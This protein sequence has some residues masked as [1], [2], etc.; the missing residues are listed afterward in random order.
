MPSRSTMESIHLVRRLVEQFW[1][2]KKNLHMMFIDLEK[3]Y[4][5]V[6][7][8]ILWR[9]L[10]ARGVP[11]AYIKSIQDMY[12][13]SKTHVRMGEEWDYSGEDEGGFG[14]EQDARSAVIL[15]RHVMRRGSNVAVRKCETLAINGF[16]RGRG[17]SKKYWRR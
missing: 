11:V 12:N 4:N 17:R 13:G 15:V 16:K 3:T 14:G 9:S 6:S 7:R 10:K 1:E 2:R 5:R 8:E